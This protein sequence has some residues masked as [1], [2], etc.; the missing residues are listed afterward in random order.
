MDTARFELERDRLLALA[1]AL[2]AVEVRETGSNHRDFEI[3]FRVES[4]SDFDSASSAAIPCSEQTIEI[5]LPLSFPDDPP[6]IRWISSLFHP[7]VS[8][9]GFLDVGDIGVEWTPELNILVICER[10]WDIARLEYVDLESA[11]NYAAQRV[12]KQNL[13]M[14]PTD[15]RPLGNI[16]Q[17]QLDNIIEYRSRG[18][19]RAPSEAV[20]PVEVVEISEPVSTSMDQKNDEVIEADVVIIEDPAKESGSAS[21]SASPS[22]AQASGQGDPVNKVPGKDSRAGNLGGRDDDDTVFVIE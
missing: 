1:T 9:S 3:R 16:N 8:S 12:W 11:N 14:T 22:A 21:P 13:I 5:N 19:L 18:P 2:P 6:Q 20:Q 10:L 7:N 15:A 4:V 17:I